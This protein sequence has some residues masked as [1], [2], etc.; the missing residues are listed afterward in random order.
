LNINST[1][2]EVVLGMIV[3]GL[4]LGFSMSLYTLIVQNALPTR[5]G[6]A[7][8]ALVFFRSIGGALA[9]GLMGS[10][11]N[12]AYLPAFRRALPAS[13]THTVPDKM[14][15]VFDNPQILLS[16]DMMTKVQAQFAAQGAQGQALFQQ[17]IEAV[18]VGLVQGIH[19][20]FIMS[21]VLM[22]ISLFAVFFLPEIALRGPARGKPIS[23]AA[24]DKEEVQE[25]V[26]S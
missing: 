8:G 1:G 14:L 12:S 24:S 6:E 26:A 23:T 13:V 15:A 5:I 3:L 16:P 2:G 19:E 20:G 21:F 17:I 22:L 9:L 25:A 10:L 4:G 7:T 18:K 11:L